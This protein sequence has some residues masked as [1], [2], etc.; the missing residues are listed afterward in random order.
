[1]AYVESAFLKCKY[2]PHYFISHLID[3]QF[4]KQPTNLQPCPPYHPVPVI[5]FFTNR[6]INKEEELTIDYFLD[7]DYIPSG[8]K[9][10]S[11]IDCLCGSINCKRHPFFTS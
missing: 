6:Q 4:A 3:G 9:S 10:G 8:D 1:M 7:A 11:K 2:L 5:A